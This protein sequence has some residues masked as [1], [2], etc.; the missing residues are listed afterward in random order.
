[1][2]F[3]VIFRVMPSKYIERYPDSTICKVIAV[4][5]GTQLETRIDNIIGVLKAD[6]YESV[7]IV[8]CVNISESSCNCR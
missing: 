1:M 5:N 3:K 4:G 6:G 8:D 7:D 2:I